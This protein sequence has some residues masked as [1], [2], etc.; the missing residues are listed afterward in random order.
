M[1][2]KANNR[3]GGSK[4]KG[5]FNNGVVRLV[6][7]I[8]KL[9]V[10]VFVAASLFGVLLFKFVNPPF[11]WLMIQRGFER[12][13]DGKDWKIDKKWVAFDDIADNMKRA[14]VAAEDQTFLEN[15]GFDFK[16]IERAIQKNAKSKKLI[17]GSTISQQTAK[18][19]FLYPGRSF[20]RKGF[21]AWFT[22]LIE[23]F[24]SKK[25]IMEVY[26][27]VIEMGDGIYG[28][29][30]ASQAYFHKPAS[31]LTKRQAAAIAVIFPSP[32]KWSAT[33]PTRY[34]KH[35]QYLIMKNMRRLGPLE[36]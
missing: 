2:K 4:T 13:A 21:E 29:E 10:I 20:V 28:I 15:H 24:W 32:L 26:L 5:F 7:R 33:R 17:G 14:A 30:A 23:T 3:K 6:L 9:A 1:A 11:T 16:A 36:F 35:R 12:K 8:L 34:L 19:V 22:I 31:K 25:R 18:N 27:N